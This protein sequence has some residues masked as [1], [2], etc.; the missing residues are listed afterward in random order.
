MY[1]HSNSLIYFMINSN[2]LQREEQLFPTRFRDRYFLNHSLNSADWTEFQR[3]LF[4]DLLMTRRNVELHKLM[5]TRISPH[6]SNTS[7]RPRIAPH[8][9]R[10]FPRQRIAVPFLTQVSMAK[11]CTS[12]SY[13]GFHGQELHLHLS[14]R[15]PRPRTAHHLSRSPR[16]KEPVTNF[17]KV[18]LVFWKTQFTSVN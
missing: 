5:T 14:R 7:L 6:L 16:G 9:S 18:L 2:S 12:I 15:F 11:N 1:K 4:F 8:L 10:R 3:H 17:R 13:A